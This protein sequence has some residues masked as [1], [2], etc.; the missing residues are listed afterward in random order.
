MSDVRFTLRISVKTLGEKPVTELV[1]DA[2]IQVGCI[3]VLI[4]QRGRYL[5]LQ[6]RDFAT[7]QE[8]EKF[9]PR[10]KVGLWSLALQYDIAFIPDFEKIVITRSP[11]PENSG[12]YFSEHFGMHGIGPVHGLANEGGYSIFRSEENIRFVI[13]GDASARAS[14]RLADVKR[15]LTEGVEHAAPLAVYT[16]DA[17]ATAFSLYLNHFSE[18]SI[19]ARFLTLMMAVEVLAPTAEKHAV[20]Q[21]L[22]LELQEKIDAQILVTPDSEAHDALEALR[23][24]LEFRKETSIRRR[25]RHLVLE[26]AS[27]DEA[28]RNILAKEVVWAYDQRGALVH[29]GSANMQDMHKAYFIALKVIKLILRVQLGLPAD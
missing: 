19:R 24:E 9:L 15:V 4:N 14:V 17:F 8:A 27:L 29:T 20:A 18:V 7:E 6:A 12:R 22:I 5:V 2:G 1:P 13:F 25:V 28:A 16:D 3:R 21:K 23:R 11:D 26:Q 10:L